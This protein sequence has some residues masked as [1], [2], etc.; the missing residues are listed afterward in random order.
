[1]S[2]QQSDPNAPFMGAS[3]PG[4]EAPV[5]PAPE[6]PSSEPA[7]R[8]RSSRRVLR[9]LDEQTPAPTDIAAPEA[10][11]V[12]SPVV[13]T[14]PSEFAVA[15]HGAG[16]DPTVLGEPEIDEPAVFTARI[17]EVASDLPAVEPLEPAPEVL[18]IEPDPD[19]GEP[20]SPPAIP[21]PPISEAPPTLVRARSDDAW[22]EA[23]EIEPD[24]M[25]LP[26]EPQVLPPSRPLPP[27]PPA[28][29]F[30]PP[31]DEVEVDLIEE[32]Q[33]TT[34]SKRP[35]R[36]PPGSIRP[37]PP[38]GEPIRILDAPRTPGLTLSMGWWNEL[39]SE[40]FQPTLDELDARGVAREVDFVERSLGVS[41]G[42]PVLDL[43]CGRGRHATELARRGYRV[44]GVDLSLPMLRRASSHAQERGQRIDLRQG[45]MRELAYDA[46]FAAVYSWSTSFGYFDDDQ[47]I[48]V[49]RR[50]HR[51]LRPGGTFL[52]DVANRDYVAATQPSVV[53]FEGEG[54]K[55][56]DEMSVDFF[57]SRLKVKR[58]LAFDG[59]GARELEYT[60]RLYSLHELGKLLQSLGFHVSEVTGHIAHRGNYFGAVSPRL[61]LLAERL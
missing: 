2:E 26:P 49:L 61:I 45:D 16:T 37:P 3:V 56:M 32:P 27:P 24:R 38:L 10:E 30:V 57:Q 9:T 44:T 48:D 33:F 14:P 41:P 11:E 55:C 50:V 20:I 31:T 59:G 52:I 15:P 46:S 13:A 60:V 23:E 25:S 1:M 28:V 39:F 35:P 22:A 36:P 42:E 53:W 18:A 6:P 5:A 19:S 54:C 4:F 58:T 34:P 40:E 51:A 47:N 12:P 7:T 17:F 29:P 21:P 8:R 43:G